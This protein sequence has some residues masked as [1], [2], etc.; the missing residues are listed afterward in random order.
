VR[1]GFCVA[2]TVTAAR[3]ENWMLGPTLSSFEHLVTHS[4]V[5]PKTRPKT[6]VQNGKRHQV[7]P[8]VGNLARKSLRN[9]FLLSLYSYPGDDFA[10]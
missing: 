9:G 8:P 1:M 10:R 2:T 7:S 6:K 3:S 5:H 4:I